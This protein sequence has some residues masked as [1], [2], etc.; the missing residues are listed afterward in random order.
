MQHGSLKRIQEALAFQTQTAENIQDQYEVYIFL[1]RNAR[2]QVAKFF[3]VTK[4]VNL[5]NKPQGPNVTPQ[6]EEH[7]NTRWNLPES[8]EK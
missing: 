6:D 1:E 3:L 4:M 7:A 5:A 2:G 8:T